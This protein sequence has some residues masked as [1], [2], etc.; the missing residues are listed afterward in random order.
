MK[1]KFILRDLPDVFYRGTLHQH[2]VVIYEPRLRLLSYLAVYLARFKYKTSERYAASLQR[3][4]NYLADEVFLYDEEVLLEWWLYVDKST[5]TAWKTSRIHKRIRNKA[6]TPRNDHIDRDA[7]DICNFLNWVKHDKKTSLAKWDGTTKTVIKKAGQLETMLKG[8]SGPSTIEVFDDTTTVDIQTTEDGVPI[9][10]F[11]DEDQDEAYSYID[12]EQMPILCGSFSDVVH[13][14]ITATGYITGLRT[15][16]VLAVPMRHEYFDGLS[17]TADPQSVKRRIAEIDNWNARTLTEFELKNQERIKAGKKAKVK[18]KLKLHTMTLKVRGKRNKLRRVT[19]NLDAWLKI[20][21]SW[22]PVFTER[23]KEYENKY[24]EISPQILWLDK[25]GEP[26]YC[27]PLDKRNHK[28]MA[29][30]L[31]SAFYYVGK[32]RK[33]NPLKLLFGFRVS[34]YCIRHTYATNFILNLMRAN[35][36]KSEQQWLNDIRAR[37]FLAKQMGHSDIK[38]TYASY[39]HHAILM[40]EDAKADKGNK[41]FNVID[42]IIKADFTKKA[43]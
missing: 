11:V 13:K 14:H 7:K 30:K 41:H 34:Y 40:L 20:M 31:Q 43:A 32:L 42:A 8:I 9:E 25:M 3:F 1:T 10:G 5:I 6:V 21:E 27:S 24:G 4:S 12:D 38:T 35:S 33:K 28:K 18:P 26:I 36:E 16:E 15:H 19:F 37:A 23:R 17:F 22:W 29:G 39:V 2:K